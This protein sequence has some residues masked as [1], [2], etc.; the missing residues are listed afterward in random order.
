MTDTQKA[1]QVQKMQM[2]DALEKVKTE[3]V[4]YEKK[5]RKQTELMHRNRKEIMSCEKK[6]TDLVEDLIRDLREHERIMKTKFAEIY[7]AQQKHH[8]AQLENFELVLIQLKSCVER[9]ESIVQR[10]ISAEILQTNQAIIERCEELLKATKPDIYKPSHVNYMVE[11][12]VKILDRIVVSDT[13]PTLSLAEVASLK[14]VRD[15]TETNF[16]IV[17]R[18]SD[19]EQCYQEEDVIIVNILNPAGGQLETEIKDTKDGKYTVT[20]VPQCVGQ[21]RAEIQVNG[22]PLSG[23]PWVVRVIG[24]H[25]YQFAFQFGSKGKERGQ[26]DLPWGIAVSDKSSTL[27]VADFNNNRIQMFGFEG[28]FLRE[29]ALKVEPVSL[30]FTESGDLLVRSFFDSRISLFT[31]NGQFI[32]YIGG[33][34]VKD[35]YYVS[36]SSD[37]RIITSDITDKKIK[38]L[39]G[40]GKNLLQSFKAPDCDETPYCVVYHQDKFVA[41]Y[42]CNSRV[43][44]FNKAGGYVHDIGSKGSGDGQFSEPRS[45]VIDKFNRLIVCDEGNRRLQ[46]FTLDGKY[47]AQIAGSI[48][49]DRY[50]RYAVI[51]NTGHLFVTVSPRHCVCVF[52]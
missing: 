3:T 6:M 18:N 45:L 49:E 19:E 33:K 44:V 34:H 5:V 27:A 8:A 29:I 47:I 37:G 36:V 10:N 21:H 39:T 15:K 43:M 13:D 7:E 9:G 51:S 22:Q 38:V 17:T 12:K 4:V 42:T 2:M 30:A 52:H 46:L 40:D 50:P 28:N 48:F 41:S 31:E 26:F 35:P 23:S 25:Q 1:A 24:P 32:S 14:D 20:Y 16:T 11:Q